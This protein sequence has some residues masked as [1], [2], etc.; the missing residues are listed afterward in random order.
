MADVIV[1]LDARAEIVGGFGLLVVLHHFAGHK[2]IA[3]PAI[4]FASIS[5]LYD[6]AKAGALAG[7]GQTAR[8]LVALTQAQ[9]ETA[10]GELSRQVGIEAVFGAPEA[11]VNVV[12]VESATI[13][14]IVFLLLI[15]HCDRHIMCCLFLNRSRS[16]P[17]G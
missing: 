6:V 17:T 12:A 15:L 7:G 4:H 10:D 1:G 14:A 16:L 8:H 2:I 5:P 13:V 3:V 9:R 11:V